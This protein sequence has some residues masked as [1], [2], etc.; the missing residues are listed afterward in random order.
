[1]VRVKICGIT[2]LADAVA[3]VEAGADAIGFVFAES[4]RKVDVPTVRGILEH[5]PPFITTVG[6]FAGLGPEEVYHIWKESGVQLAQI[7]GMDDRLM[8]LISRENNNKVNQIIYALRVKS[9]RDIEVAATN[10][11]IDRSV[12][13]L[14][15]THVEGLMGGTGKTFDWSLAVKAKSL[16]K[17]IILAGGLTPENVV[18]AVQM[19]QPYAVDVSTGVEAVPGKKDHAKIKEFVKNAKQCVR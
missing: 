1:V 6:V 2:N 10:H 11:L 14:L 9:Q 19:V 3:A 8:E 7:H 4:P 13:V 12:A 18:S 15:D 5:L 17:P 16:R